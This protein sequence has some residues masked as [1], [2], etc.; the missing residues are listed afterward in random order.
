[1]RFFILDR[2]FNNSFFSL[3]NV[4][5]SIPNNDIYVT[6]IRCNFFELLLILNFDTF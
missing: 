3:N 2:L 1:M 5:D 4:R 6:I